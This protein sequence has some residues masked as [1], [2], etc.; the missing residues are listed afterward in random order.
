MHRR[1]SNIKLRRELIKIAFQLCR[2]S[3]TPASKPLPLAE[4]IRQPANRITGIAQKPKTSIIAASE[5]KLSNDCVHVPLAH[6]RTFALNEPSGCGISKAVLLK[7]VK[8]PAEF[9]SKRDSNHGGKSEVE[10]QQRHRNN[11]AG[12]SA[13]GD[14]AWRKASHN[15][16]DGIAVDQ[17]IRVTRTP[18]SFIFAVTPS[19]SP[20]VL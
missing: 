10:P 9:V 6:K 16:N 13:R 2:D 17:S 5:L 14:T 20:S 4:Q 12:N 18:S 8:P 19:V 7:R 1:V 11:A 3:F 15:R